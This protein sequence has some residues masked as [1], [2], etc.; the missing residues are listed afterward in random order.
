MTTPVRIIPGIPSDQYD[1]AAALYWAAF[2]AKLGRIMRPE[3][4]ALA[5]FQRA[6][7]PG[8]AIS[9]V[10]GDGR[11]MGLAGFKTAQ[12]AMTGGG[13]RDLVAA[14]GWAGAAWR[15]LALS[16]L[17]RPV[18]A[19]TLLMDG[20]CVAPDARGQGLGTRL[21]HAIKSEAAA[22]GLDRVRLDVIDSNPRARALYE[23]EGFV[24]Q[25]TEDI[26]PLRHIF[27]FRSATQ[28]L[29]TL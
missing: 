22:R 10:R 26:G 21:L 2:G 27:G 13:F 24:A 5:F 4:R 16:P 9:A 25:R 14:Y 17:E 7:D 3:A 20:I 15:A 8:F 19:G 6:L 23:R 29:C 1:R 18:A 12:G 11:L 28:M